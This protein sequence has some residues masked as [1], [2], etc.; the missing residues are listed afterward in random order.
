MITV[1]VAGDNGVYTTHEVEEGTTV[2]GLLES[3]GQ[4]T[5]GVNISLDENVC[6]D[7]NTELTNEAIVLLTRKDG[8]NL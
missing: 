2:A 3:I 4:P 6:L 1:Y 5:T 7:V 8:G